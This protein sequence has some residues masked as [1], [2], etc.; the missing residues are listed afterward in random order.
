MMFW[1][2]S[3]WLARVVEAV[4]APLA[5]QG[6]VTLAAVELDAPDVVPVDVLLLLPARMPS[7][8]R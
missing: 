3:T 7:R 8:D 4:D 5:F 2:L 1:P 6:G